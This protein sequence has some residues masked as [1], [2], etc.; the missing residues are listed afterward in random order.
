MTQ[1]S[2]LE[3]QL[4]DNKPN[5]FKVNLSDG[6]WGYL[7]EKDSDIGLRE[8]DEITFTAETPT[9]KSYKKLTIKKSGQSSAPPPPPN[10]TAQSNKPSVTPSSVAAL[11]ADAT[12]QAMRYIVDCFIA[13][14]MT[15]EQIQAKHKELSG[16]LYDSI[17]DI[18][19]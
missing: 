18:N 16:Y 1:I 12:I 6:T 17:D 7:V 2:K 3:Q 15:F 10:L 4:K 11:K 19:L 14:K 5:G 9:G 8:G 13:D